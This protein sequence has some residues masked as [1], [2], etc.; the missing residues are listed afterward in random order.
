MQWVSFTNTNR[1][2]L[3]REIIAVYSEN[4]MKLT[5][6]G[7]NVERNINP[8]GTYSNHCVTSTLEEKDKPA[9]HFDKV[10]M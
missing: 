2:R 10:F 8:N 4:H 7:S 3:F 5:A 6:F 1:L 9:E